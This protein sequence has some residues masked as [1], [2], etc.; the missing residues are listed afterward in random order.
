[1]DFNLGGNEEFWKLFAQERNM[2][3]LRCGRHQVT[4]VF[5]TNQRREEEMETT[6]RVLSPSR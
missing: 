5:G 6:R 3:R 4:V 2:S 1:M